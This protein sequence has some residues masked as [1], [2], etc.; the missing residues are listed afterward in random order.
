MAFGKSLELKWLKRDKPIEPR[1][2]V[3]RDR[4]LRGKARIRARKA[5][6]KAA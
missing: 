6:R 5:A 4:S 2:T 1:E 3:D